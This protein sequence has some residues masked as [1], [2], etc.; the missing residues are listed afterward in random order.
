MVE[1]AIAVVRIARLCE[2]GWRHPKNGHPELGGDGLAIE[3]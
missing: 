1:V 2:S 3:G